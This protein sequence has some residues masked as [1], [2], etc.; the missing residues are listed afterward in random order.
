MS[1]V[2]RSAS[3]KVTSSSVRPLLGIWLSPRETIRWLVA[4]DPT[5]GVVVI[6]WIAGIA[7]FLDA[8]LPKVEPKLPVGVAILMAIAAGPLVIF[9]LVFV[10]AYLTAGT[11]RLLGGRAGLLELRAALAWANA[12]LLGFLVLWA[13]HGIAAVPRPAMQ[14]LGI[15]L[16]LWAGILAVVL[17]A[18]V[19]RFSVGRSLGSIVLAWVAKIAIIVGIVVS[20]S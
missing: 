5:R 7:V 3:P 11:G 18:E 12:P 6:S 4:T 8:L 20:A 19:Q 13:V 16:F 10:E 14:A 17:V 2:T 15:A 9:L 1:F